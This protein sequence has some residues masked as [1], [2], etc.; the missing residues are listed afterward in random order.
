[1]KITKKILISAL[2]ISPLTTLAFIPSVV[3]P[4]EVKTCGTNTWKIKAD[5]YLDNSDYANIIKKLIKEFDIN[6]IKFAT[7][8][9]E[10][11][12]EIENIKNSINYKIW[13]QEN[14]V[15]QIEKYSPIAGKNKKEKLKELNKFYIDC[16]NSK[17]KTLEEIENKLFTIVMKDDYKESMKKYYSSEALKTVITKIKHVAYEIK[18]TTDKCIE[19]INDKK[20]D[21]KYQKEFDNLIE[22]QKE[23]LIELNEQR[24]MLE[25]HFELK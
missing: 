2:A 18:N 10:L 20:V 9:Y 5:S 17:L 4:N 12:I 3:R 19:K 15:E 11:V 16:L 22:K 24:K 13:E 23:L 8:G 14:E 21:E 25:K 6:I 1:M 7:S